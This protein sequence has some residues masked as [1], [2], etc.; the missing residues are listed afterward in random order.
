VQSYLDRLDWG[1]VACAELVPDVN[2]LLDD[3]IAD[4]DTL[5]AA[6]AAASSKPPAQRKRRPPARVAA[7]TDATEG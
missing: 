2:D 1:L 4:I 6:A 5:A 7:Q 3:I